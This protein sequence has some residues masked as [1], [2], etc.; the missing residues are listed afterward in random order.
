MPKAHQ[1]TTET[2]FHHWRRG[3]AGAGKAMAQRFTDWYYAIA[4]SRLGEVEGERPFRAACAKFSKGVVKVDDTRRLLGWAHNIARKQLHRRVEG[5]RVP[6]GDFPNAFTRRQ[7]PKALLAQVRTEMPRQ[8]ALLEDAYTHGKLPDDLIEVLHA[9][10][11]IKAFL[12]DNHDVPFKVTPRDPDPDRAPLTLY[13]A[14]KLANDAEDVHF[15]LYMLNEQ[16]ICQDVAEFAH[17]AIA[18]RG[19]V[20]RSPSVVPQP[21]QRAPE[22]A[23][24]PAPVSRP[25]P[26]PAPAAAQPEAPPVVPKEAAPNDGQRNNVIFIALFLAL[27]LAVL[28]ALFVATSAS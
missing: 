6:D 13:E 8:M 26:A 23:P 14:G 19:G 4:I 12:R 25:A 21:A 9:R 10:Y 11:A 24:Q 15:E 27:A 3:D 17:Y 7:S 18:L 2:L 22:P 16:E 20:G 28:Y 1:S 5:G